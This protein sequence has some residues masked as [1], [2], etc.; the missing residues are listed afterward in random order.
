MPIEGEATDASASTKFDDHSLPVVP[1]V[2]ATSSPQEARSIEIASNGGSAASAP[3]VGREVSQFVEADPLEAVGEAQID[4]ARF[5][6]V[7]YEGILVAMVRHVVEVESP[8]LDSVLARRVARAHGFART[9]ARIQERIEQRA[10]VEF[11]CTEE[12]GVGTFYW[13]KDMAPGSAVPYRA[14]LEDGAFRGVEEICMQELA[15]LAQRTLG[16]GL[17]EKTP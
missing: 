6:D 13:P 9:G 16:Q 4:A 8:I 1:A 12:D 11:A 3:K 15:S 5:F 7:A 17:G 10:A 2:S 14:P